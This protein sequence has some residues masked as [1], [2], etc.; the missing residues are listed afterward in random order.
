MTTDK[1]RYYKYTSKEEYDEAFYQHIVDREGTSL[2]VHIDPVGIVTLPGGIATMHKNGETLRQLSKTEIDQTL[3]SAGIAPLN[4]E[5][6]QKIVQVNKQAEVIARANLF[7]TDKKISKDDHT[8]ITQKAVQAGK[9]I[10][11]LESDF[12]LDIKL[13]ED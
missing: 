1:D 9:V 3:A 13:T 8:D 2:K 6:Y 12:P 10:L 11:K 5:N 7:L 4:E